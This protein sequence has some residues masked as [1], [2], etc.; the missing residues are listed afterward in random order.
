MNYEDIKK[1]A[2]EEVNKE[3]GE[4]ARKTLV[5]LYRKLAKAQEIVSNI[6]HEISL[7]ESKLADKYPKVKRVK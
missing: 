3:I 7:E 1:E 4:G 5:E 6:E 2:L